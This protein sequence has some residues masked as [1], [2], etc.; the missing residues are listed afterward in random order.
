MGGQVQAIPKSESVES[1]LQETPPLPYA[2]DR[3]IVKFKAGLQISSQRSGILFTNAPTLNALMSEMGVSS[4]APLFNV[5]EL[6]SDSDLATI[7]VL[8][9]SSGQDIPHLIS[10]LSLDSNIEWAEPDYLAYPAATVPN[11]PR[12]PAQWGIDK[13]NASTAWDTTTGSA[14]VPI[15]IIDSGI[16]D[17]HPDLS[18]RLWVN[19][20][21][22]AGNGVDDDNNGYIDDVNG[23]N[24]VDDNNNPADDNGHGTQVAGIA[25]A[26]SNNS[27]G[28]AGVCWHCSLMNVKV[29]SAAGVANYSDIAAGVLYAAQKGAQVINLSLGGYSNSSALQSA[30]QEAVNSYDSV[31]VAGAG[32]DNQQTPFYPAAYPEVMAVAG[33]DQT[34]AKAANSNY[35]D[36]VAVAAPAV[37]ITTTFMGGDYGA[38]DGTSFATPFVAGVAGLLRSQY[39]DWS[40]NTVWAQIVQTADNL[41]RL[42]NTVRSDLGSGRVNAA[43][44]VSTPPQPL[45]TYTSHAI[46]GI[47]EGRPEPGTTVDLDVTLYNGWADADNV[48][49]TLTSSS[50]YVTIV[51]GSAFYG[52]IP[53]Y[54]SGTNATSFQFSVSGSA[55]Y[56]DDLSFTLTLS[57]DG[58]YADN[59]SFFLQTASEVIYPDATITTQIWF[60]DRV[61]VI[62]KET[63]IPPGETLTIEPGTEIRFDGAY[64]FSVA[65]TLIADGSEGQEIIFTSNKA[66]PA[67]GDWGR[68][69]ILD[70]SI[71]ASF[72]SQGDYTGGSIIRNAIIEY[73]CGVGLNNAAPYIADSEL[74]FINGSGIS[75]DGESG[76]VIA[77]N[78]LSGEGSDANY[79]GMH[80]SVSGDFLVMGN[81]VSIGY[82]GIIANGPGVIS[83]NSVENMS[84]SGIAARYTLNVTQNRVVNC[85]IGMYLTT[86][87]YVSQN[88]VG[89]NET[90]GLHINGTPTVINNTILMNGGAGI[91]IETGSPSLHN[92]NLIRSTNGYALQNAT[93]N[94]IDAT[95]NWWGTAVVDDIKSAIFDGLDDFNLGVVD[96]SSYLSNPESAAP[97]YVV[98]VN[99]S[100]DTTLGIQTA[101]FDVV[102]SREMNETTA[103]TITFYNEKKE[104]WE[105][106]TPENSIIPGQI[107]VVETTSDGSVWFG[108]N[109]ALIRYKD[110]SW[111]MFDTT[112]AGIGIWNIRA[113][114]EDLDG[115]FW[116]IGTMGFAH[117]IDDNFE[118]YHFQD[119]PI[120]GDGISSGTIDIFGNLWISSSVF[121]GYS[122]LTKFDGQTWETFDPIDFGWDG[123]Y[124]MRKLFSDYYG[125]IWIG[126]YHHGFSKFNG[127]TW[128]FYTTENSEIPTNDVGKIS[129]ASD[130]SIWFGT[131][132]STLEKF[133]ND[134]WTSYDLSNQI[135]SSLYTADIAFDLDGS[136]WINGSNDVLIHFQAPDDLSLYPFPQEGVYFEIA[137]DQFGNKWIGSSDGGMGGPDGVSVFYGGDI[138]SL[139]EGAQWIDNHTYRVT[140]EITSLIPRGDYVINIS[141]VF[142][143]DGVEIPSIEGYTFTVDYAGGISDTTSPNPPTVTACAGTTIDNISAEWIAS[144]PESNITMYSYAIGTT[145]GGSD[146]INWTNTA[147]NSFDRSGLTLLNGQPYYVSVKARNEGGLWSLIATPEAI[148]QGS[149]VCTTTF[150]RIF[151]PMVS[152]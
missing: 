141:G 99:I 53:V 137:V 33:T 127:V 32:N 35:G 90:K 22:I 73:G 121:P 76:L 131:E 100:P 12:F 65:G 2:A 132:N 138:Y 152:R 146:V 28:I 8:H 109:T 81:T 86:S 5:T 6:R 113:I 107:E 10:V 93:S 112:D 46:D 94:G 115:T 87:G 30:V 44:A 145:P 70:S 150:T 79:V 140:Y 36:W 103:P 126:T 96:Y 98:D 71:N 133:L 49:A 58:G 24:F 134:E 139:V 148:Y 69:K 119:T 3:I 41:T 27:I 34:D 118:I 61:Y 64:S 116:V 151:I 18:G 122:F 13:I 45:L 66:N 144:D 56:G 59:I 21:E 52:S 117:L 105:V 48:Q 130:G 120:P 78:T 20:G 4:G 89:K 114:V 68:I 55:P 39:S 14:T 62:N 17:T 88:F 23:W 83:N 40:A 19:P 74:R 136:L 54:A 124:D 129:F 43:V 82:V 128:R 80:F 110:N 106:Y 37:G 135:E 11:D 108:T 67:P 111:D 142:G 47:T 7:Y 72:D 125:S 143:T 104:T 29:M 51:T 92:N 9:T 60:N 91:Y 42:S 147:D 15:A 38:V 102:F 16:D 63:G 85:D 84:G 149:G 75:G 95:N 25:G 50:P 97:A 101:T 123:L 1:D 77:D 31:L 26:S 57:A